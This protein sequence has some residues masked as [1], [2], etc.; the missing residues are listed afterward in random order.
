VLVDAGDGLEVID[1][2]ETTGRVHGMTVADLDGDYDRDLVVAV[3]GDPSLWLLQLRA[4][5]YSDALALPASGAVGTV[6][7]LD[8]D[9]DGLLE[10]V[11][12]PHEGTGSLQVVEVDP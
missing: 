3:D 1:R 4:G 8:V 6:R 2:V 12:G 11:L 10:L 7:A 5:W 9:R